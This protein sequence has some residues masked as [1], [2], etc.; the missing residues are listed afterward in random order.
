MP[1]RCNRALVAA[2]SPADAQALMRKLF[3]AINTGKLPPDTLRFAQ[4]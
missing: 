2:D 4:P 3:V 1:S